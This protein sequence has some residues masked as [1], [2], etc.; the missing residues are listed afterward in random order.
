MHPAEAGVLGQA[1]LLEPG[2][3][4]MAVALSKS[5]GRRG[6]GTPQRLGV[7]SMRME[8]PEDWKCSCLDLIIDNILSIIKDAQACPNSTHHKIC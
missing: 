2:S 5:H 3:C 6:G 4:Y 7:K 8:E 1:R